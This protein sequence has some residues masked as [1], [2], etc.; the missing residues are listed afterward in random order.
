M[1]QSVAYD[2]KGKHLLAF[3]FAIPL[4]GPRVSRGA[5]LQRFHLVVLRAFYVSSPTRSVIP[6]HL[7]NLLPVR[8]TIHRN[9]LRG[10]RVNS[11]DVTFNRLG[12]DSYRT[13]KS[14]SFKTFP[15][16]ALKALN[17]ALLGH[18][19]QGMKVATNTELQTRPQQRDLTPDPSPQPKPRYSKEPE[20]GLYCTTLRRT[21]NT[22]QGSVH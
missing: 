16:S 7:I 9:H 21:P 18:P 10:M 1:I 4:Y 15:I 5:T 3:M 14:C 12:K 2:Y 19:S 6:N 8:C 11:L 13:V 22:L 17:F 20:Q